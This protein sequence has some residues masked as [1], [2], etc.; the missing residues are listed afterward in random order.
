MRKLI[1]ISTKAF[2]KKDL[3]KIRNNLV[4]FLKSENIIKT[5]LEYVLCRKYTG[6]LFG[7]LNIIG[8][9]PI[10]HQTTLEINGLSSS[11][12]YD[13]KKNILVLKESASIEL[14]NL[15]DIA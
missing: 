5:K 1:S 4:L 12:Q 11:S 9:P 14:M 13:G 8:V 6:D 7:L 2:T 15:D 10:L 3:A